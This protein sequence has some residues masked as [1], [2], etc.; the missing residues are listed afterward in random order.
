LRADTLTLTMKE[1]GQNA[2][3]FPAKKFNGEKTVVITDQRDFVFPSTYKPASSP[4]DGFAMIPPL[5]GDFQDEKT[6]FRAELSVSQEGALFQIKG[7]IR[8]SPLSR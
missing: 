7:V 5:P 6:G 2:E 3:S 1:P 4:K 8:K